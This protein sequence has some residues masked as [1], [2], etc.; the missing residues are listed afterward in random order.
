MRFRCD[1]IVPL[2]VPASGRNDLLSFRYDIRST[3]SVVVAAGCSYTMSFDPFP[4]KRIESM[5]MRL[6]CAEENVN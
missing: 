1:A 6:W 2:S 5:A 4:S 3:T